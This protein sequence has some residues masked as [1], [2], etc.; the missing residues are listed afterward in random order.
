MF[1]K[2]WH[3]QKVG[4]SINSPRFKAIDFKLNFDDETET[5]RFASKSKTENTK[6]WV[7]FFLSPSDCFDDRRRDVRRFFRT[8]VASAGARYFQPSGPHSFSFCFS[9]GQ[10]SAARNN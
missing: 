10:E 6:N 7:N 5:D 3:F 4:S 1:L 9:E 2:I 8:S